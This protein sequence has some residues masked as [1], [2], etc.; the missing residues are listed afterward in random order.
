VFVSS[1]CLLGIDIRVATLLEKM[2]LFSQFLMKR[3][4][5]SLNFQPTMTSFDTSED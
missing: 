4:D 5:G 2:F 1:C 3:F